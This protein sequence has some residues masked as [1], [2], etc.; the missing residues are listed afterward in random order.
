[1]AA[2]NVNLTYISAA[3]PV[4]GGSGILAFGGASLQEL[5]YIGT[6]TLIG[7][8]AV[9]NAIVNFIDGVNALPFIPTAVMAF[10]TGGNAT[11]T[12]AVT[13]TQNITNVNCNVQFASAPGAAAQV[14][15]GV[16]VMK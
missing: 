5:S 3:A 12:I 4:A 1:M 16:V 14:I 10:R 8:G 11:S 9:T 7:D 13:G 6:A 2:S 15:V